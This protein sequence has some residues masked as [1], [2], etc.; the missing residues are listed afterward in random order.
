MDHR[1]FPRNH[2]ETNVYQHL[3]T[4]GDKYY[5]DSLFT[6]PAPTLTD[7]RAPIPW[8]LRSERRS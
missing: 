5:I 3:P 8:E 7:V 6:A 1:L 4:T 2:A